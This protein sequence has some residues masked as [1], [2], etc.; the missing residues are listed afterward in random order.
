MTLF[1]VARAYSRR[2]PLAKSLLTEDDVRTYLGCV[3]VD[4]LWRTNT[5]LTVPKG[6]KIKQLSP[7]A[8]DRYK[9]RT[10]GKSYEALGVLTKG[11]GAGAGPHS[12]PAEPAR[13]AG[14]ELRRLEDLENNV[15]AITDVIK[16]W[17]R[18]D[19]DDSRVA[20]EDDAESPGISHTAADGGG[21]PPY[22]V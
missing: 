20:M 2:V 21:V 17:Q 22:K 15:R 13:G 9:I 6:L 12:L 11:E 1:D 18:S 10:A 8:W 5:L 7:E 4:A 16:E 14:L 3:L 19:D